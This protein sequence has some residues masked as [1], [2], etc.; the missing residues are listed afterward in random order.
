[1]SSTLEQLT[2]RAARAEVEITALEEELEEL[3]RG[4]VVEEPEELIMLREENT[5]LR[6]VSEYLE[7]ITI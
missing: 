3:E 7:V 4:G 2:D 6:L 5:R 1:M